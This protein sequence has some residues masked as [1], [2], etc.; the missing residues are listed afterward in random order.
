MTSEE[1]AAAG[2]PPVE[3]DMQGIEIG[4]LS[5]ENPAADGSGNRE[6]GELG[7]EGENIEDVDADLKDL[8]SAKR[9]KTLPA[10]F[11]FGE[12]K[13]TADLIREYEA[14]GFFPTGNGSTPL[15]EEIPTPEANEIVVFR[16][17]SLAG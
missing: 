13:V 3:E 2:L 14:T 4:Q 12:S 9:S 15:D 11:V 7:S 16:E 6:E 5:E 10:S 8:V 1:L 17:F